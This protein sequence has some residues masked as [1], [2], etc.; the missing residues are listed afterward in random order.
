MYKDDIHKELVSELAESIKTSKTEVMVN[1]LMLG[2][3]ENEVANR[4]ISGTDK[5]YTDEA[6]KAISYTKE[7][8]KFI[9][10]RITALHIAH[11]SMRE[12][13][14]KKL[15]LIGVT[16]ARSLMDMDN[17]GDGEKYMEYKYNISESLIRMVELCG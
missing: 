8:V 14:P 10:Y 7:F 9:D 13:G 5:E 12:I 1:K 4:L 16:C 6:M 11:S 15:T 17:G 2:G 3:L